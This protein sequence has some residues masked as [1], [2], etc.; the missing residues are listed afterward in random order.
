MQEKGVW[1]SF[2]IA[3]TLSIILSGILLFGMVRKLKKL[4]DG[5]DPSILGSKI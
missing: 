2:P 5:D 3:D 1:A 4:K